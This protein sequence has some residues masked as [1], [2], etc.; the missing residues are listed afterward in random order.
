MN[1]KTLFCIFLA[2]ALFEK[3]VHCDEINID[4]SNIKV[5]DKGNIIN[6]LDVKVDFPNKN[7]EVEGGVTSQ[8]TIK[9][10]IN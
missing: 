2:F 8:F 10:K 4:S 3:S 9:K 6:A 5:L 7:I 1:I